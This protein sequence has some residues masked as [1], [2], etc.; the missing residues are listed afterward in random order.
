MSGVVGR[1]LR[2]LFILNFT[3]TIQ[4]RFM[5]LL[6]IR[7]AITR[8]AILFS[9]GRVRYYASTDSLHVSKVIGSDCTAFR[10]GFTAY[11]V[12]RPNYISQRAYLMYHAACKAEFQPFNRSY[13]QLT[14][15]NFL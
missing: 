15:F 9:L 2:P 12:L 3:S 1:S 7:F 14:F 10:L 5:L 13:S 6:F 8:A 4:T 11:F